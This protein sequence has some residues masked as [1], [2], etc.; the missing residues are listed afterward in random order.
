M[1]WLWPSI[2]NIADEFVSKKVCS[3]FPVYSNLVFVEIDFLIAIFNAHLLRVCN[4]ESDTENLRRPHL[5][6]KNVFI[7]GILNLWLR[8]IFAWRNNMSF[9]FKWGTCVWHALTVC[10]P[11]QVCHVRKLFGRNISGFILKIDTSNI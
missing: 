1:Y 2:K 3:K 4:K 11:A 9:L 7:S 5:N 8:Y 6:L 10:V